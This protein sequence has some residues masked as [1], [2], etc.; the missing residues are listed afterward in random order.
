MG[1]RDNLKKKLVRQKGFQGR[2][3]L[4]RLRLERQ[5]FLHSGMV[6]RGSNHYSPTSPLRPQVPLVL[7]GLTDP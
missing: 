2:G 6:L 4:L 3:V 5:D 7:L 1:R